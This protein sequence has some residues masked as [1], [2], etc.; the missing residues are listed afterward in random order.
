MGLQGHQQEGRPAWTRVRQRDP[1]I[2]DVV[3]A[4]AD[5]EWRYTAA[6]DGETVL[7]LAAPNPLLLW[8]LRGG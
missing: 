5:C 1:S 6:G 4:G 3:S 2:T 8:L 7:L